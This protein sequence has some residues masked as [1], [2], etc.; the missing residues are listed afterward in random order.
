MICKKEQ[1]VEKAVRWKK[2]H[3]SAGQKV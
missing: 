2:V 1:K 3:K